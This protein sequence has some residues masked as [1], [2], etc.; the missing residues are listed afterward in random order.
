MASII[1]TEAAKTMAGMAGQT[2][3][4]DLGRMFPKTQAA[5]RNVYRDTADSMVSGSEQIEDK[6]IETHEKIKKAVNENLA[7]AVPAGVLAI[8]LASMTAG[9]AF[10]ATTVVAPGTMI[11]SVAGVGLGLGGGAG[12]GMVAAGAGGAVVATGL[13]IPLCVVAGLA[14]SSLYVYKLL[15]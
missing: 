1:A 9:I 14:A 6:I 11:V 13:A 12:I 7:I 10:T 4:G 5:I 8:Q 3:G 2:V 15:K